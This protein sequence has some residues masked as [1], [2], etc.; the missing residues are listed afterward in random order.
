MAVT[1]LF[2]GGVD[3]LCHLRWAQR[4]YSHVTAVYYDVGQAYAE[5]ESRDARILVQRLGVPFRI[6]QPMSLHEDPITAQVALRNMLFI[7][8]A[9]QAVDAVVFGML[10]GETPVDKNPRFVRRLQTLLRSQRTTDF[11]ILTPFASYT[12]AEMIREYQQHYGNEYLDGTVGCFATASPMCGRC[13]SCINRWL[14]WEECL[15]PQERYLV[16]PAQAMLEKLRAMRGRPKQWNVSNAWAR[17]RWL[18]E[19]KRQLDRYSRAKYDMSA[20]RYVHL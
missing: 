6:E 20:W 2:S 14:A 16:H 3:S 15:L 12:K 10:Q 8:W 11:D 1:V 9:S 13:W 18:R 4:Q 5:R 7:T 19:M 17:R